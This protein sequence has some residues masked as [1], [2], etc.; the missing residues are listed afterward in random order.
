MDSWKSQHQDVQPPGYDLGRWEVTEQ[1][2]KRKQEGKP[3]K[4]SSM[5]EWC[6]QEEG[7]LGSAH[8]R[9]TMSGRRQKGKEDA[10]WCQ[11]GLGSM[12]NCATDK[13]VT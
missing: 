4:K 5:T 9:Y 13:Q 10:L 1:E 6:G 8:R 11:M 12:L 7:S 2:M 3:K